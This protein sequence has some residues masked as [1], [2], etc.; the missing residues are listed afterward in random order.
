M[1]VVLATSKS[2]SKPPVALSTSTTASSTTTTVLP[3]STTLSAATKLMN[4]I[5]TEFRNDC[6]QPSTPTF[7]P[8]QTAEWDCDGPAGAAMSFIYYSSWPTR[9]AMNTAY[10]A[11][12]SSEGI[13]PNQKECLKSSFV[14]KCTDVFTSGNDFKDNDLAE[15][16]FSCGTNQMCPNMVFTSDDDVIQ[17]IQAGPGKG[18]ALNTYWQQTVSFLSNNA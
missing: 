16:N 18:Q 6:T 4:L 15:F 8:G 5:P 2:T 1:G 14:P 17:V 7:F 11:F 10:S 9:A 12:I 13:T 3:T